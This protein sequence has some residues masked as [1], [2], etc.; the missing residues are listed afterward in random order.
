MRKVSPDPGFA[1]ELECPHMKSA[2]TKVVSCACLLLLFLPLGATAQ[3]NADDEPSAVLNF[4]VLKEDNGKPVRSAAVIMHPVNTNGK[5]SRGGLEL[6]TDANGKTSFDGVP[7]GK[8]RVQVL[9]SG[10]QTFG[11]DY[12]INKASMDF[13][14][15]LKR[16]QGQ[17]SIYENH[18]DQTNNGT[19][20]QKKDDKPADPNAKP[21]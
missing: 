21:Q 18:P 11:E 16:P 15:K 20:N 19:Q 3:K 17:Y 6:K 10:F 4:L 13:T 14:I 9:A 7:Y 8:L 1:E 2:R 5:Q 12:D